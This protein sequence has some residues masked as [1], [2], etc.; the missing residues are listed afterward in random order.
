MLWTPADNELTAKTA[1]PVLSTVATPR[2][3]LPSVKVTA[4]VGIAEA[5]PEATTLAVRLA[6]WPKALG[7]GFAVKAVTL[8]ALLTTCEI[9]LDAE[10][11]KLPSPE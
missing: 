5:P 11:E 10:V 3:V 8:A 9:A 1:L 6:G 7:L 4:P 2:V